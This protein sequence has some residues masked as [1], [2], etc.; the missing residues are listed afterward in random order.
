MPPVVPPVTGPTAIEST[1]TGRPSQVVSRSVVAPVRAEAKPTGSGRPAD[2]GVTTADAPVETTV[3]DAIPIIPSAGATT[4]S[5]PANGPST[6]NPGWAASSPETTVVVPS[7][8]VPPA[9]PPVVAVSED[10]PTSAARSRS[11]ASE[12]EASVVATAA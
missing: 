11:S 4:A 5:V 6:A 2:A 9:T 8:A 12:V 10:P 7:I 1:R 3:G